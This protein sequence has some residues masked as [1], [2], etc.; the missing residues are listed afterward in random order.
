MIAT[1]QIAAALLAAVIGQTAPGVRVNS[2]SCF[3]DQTIVG[4]T[5]RHRIVVRRG[6]SWSPVLP[7]LEGDFLWRSPDDR[8]F[9]V[10]AGPL[11]AEIPHATRTS[12]RWT[13]PDG[14]A[15]PRCAF[16]NRVVAV[17]PERMYRLEAAGQMLDIGPTPL[18]AEGTRRVQAPHLIG[19]QEHLVVCFGTS[20]REDDDREG[21][22]QASSPKRY[23]YPVDFGDP[24]TALQASAFAAPFVCSGVVVSVRRGATQTRDLVTGA[25]LGHMNGAARHGSGC[26]DPGRVLIVGKTEIWIAGLPGLRRQ[27]HRSIGRQIETASICGNSLAIITNGQSQPTLVELPTTR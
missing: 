23:H 18:D 1:Q 15:L 26:L 10:S 24:V 14:V 27:W 2:I 12:A 16:L 5:D 20:V 19:D 3:A 6:S 9:A 25:S 22:C 21:E 4:L 13:F 7:A 17:T 8:M 11:M